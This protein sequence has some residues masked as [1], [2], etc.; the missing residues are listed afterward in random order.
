MSNKPGLRDH[1]LRIMEGVLVWEG[2]IGNARVRDLFGLQVVQS[3]RL[4]AEFRQRME[5][6]IVED[7]R[8]KTFKPASQGCIGS[9]VSLAEYAQMTH[10]NELGNPSVIDARYDLTTVSPAIFSVIRKAATKGT[11]VSI[12]YASMAHPS[13]EV[14]SVFP[15][16]IVLVGR[17]WH[18]RAWCEKRQQFRDFNLG[19]I[20]SAEALPLSAPHAQ[21]A[22][23]YWQRMAEIR[24]AAH[25]ALSLEQQ[26][27]VQ[28]ECLNSAKEKSIQVRACL[29]AY[30]IQDLRA[31]M[32]LENER[33]PEFQLEILNADEL[34]P[35]LFS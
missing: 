4:L 3:S 5:G 2:E 23:I 29:A 14:R 11:G 7:P 1:R 21:S 8:S 16:S 9:D 12:Q 26:I 17:R 20:R 27:I 28:H 25:R 10:L 31:A 15:H 33:P 35:L 24:L 34:R 22:D 30:V 6:Q 32:S 13:F 19:R 18:V